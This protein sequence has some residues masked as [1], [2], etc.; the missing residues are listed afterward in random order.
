[1]KS[2]MLLTTIFL[3]SFMVTISQDLRNRSVDEKMIMFLSS[4]PDSS[5][6]KPRRTKD[7]R[8]AVFIE[9]I[10][11]SS[12]TKEKQNT[13]VKSMVDIVSDYVVSDSFKVYPTLYLAFKYPGGFHLDTFNLTQKNLSKYRGINKRTSEEKI[14]TFMRS[15]NY[16]NNLVVKP[17]GIMVTLSVKKQFWQSNWD[18]VYYEL[19]ETSD[20]I[21]DYAIKQNWKKYNNLIFDLVTED[22]IKLISYV[23]PVLEKGLGEVKLGVAN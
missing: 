11:D 8:C 10:F 4:L 16:N 1:M 13:L 15:I 14:K 19:K 23:Y 6:M 20:F 7:G 18:H 2:K 22:G 9:R 17:Y 5:R 3:F 21:F 12:I